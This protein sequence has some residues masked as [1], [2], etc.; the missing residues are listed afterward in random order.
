MRDKAAFADW[1]KG[2][3]YDKDTAT[4]RCM[5]CAEAYARGEVFP[6]EGRFFDARGKIAA[7]IEREHGSVFEAL[8]TQGKAVTGLSDTQSDMMR[9]FYKGIPD[10]DIAAAAGTSPSTVRYQRH[11]LRERARK[12]RVFL[13]LS[14]LMEESLAGRANDDLLD[15]HPGAT[16]VDDRYL[17]TEAEAERI[18]AGS[19]LSMD[20]MKLKTF[21]PKEKKKLVVLR[22]IAGRFE[23]GKRYTARQVD[24]LLSSIY[25]DYATLR[26]YLIEYGFMDR[27]RDGREYWRIYT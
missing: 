6:L 3:R 10:K 19:F 13:A 9:S 15:I 1:K 23:R 2:Y 22:A 4:F 18:L 20:P 12:A 24:E 26:R 27:T 16:M 5:F 11:A 25:D 7:H 8:L 17:T 14:E 21:P